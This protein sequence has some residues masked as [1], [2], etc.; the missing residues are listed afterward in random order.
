M[1]VYMYVC[2]YVYMYIYVCMY[3]Y[4][5]IQ[6]HVHLYALSDCMNVAL[7]SMLADT[8]VW[9]ITETPIP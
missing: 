1:Y 3:V 5:C 9:D 4:I 8:C 2:M 7:Y 6:M